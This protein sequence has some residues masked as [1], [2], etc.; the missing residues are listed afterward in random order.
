MLDQLDQLAAEVSAAGLSRPDLESLLYRLSG[1]ERRLFLRLTR[2]PALTTE[3]RS[4]CSIG[5][6]SQVRSSLNAK[7]AAADDPRRVV[8]RL[9][10]HRNV[11]GESG[12]LGSWQLV[13]EAGHERRAA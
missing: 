6:I 4:E 3:L 10:P 5:N 12:Q 2:G 1:Q 8:C 9:Q 7:L 11:Y 13:V